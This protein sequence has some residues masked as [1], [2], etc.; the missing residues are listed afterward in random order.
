MSGNEG[1]PDARTTELEKER[2]GI[3]EEYGFIFS[4]PESLDPSIAI[5]KGS[6]FMISTSDF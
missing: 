2:D 4:T 5:E 1:E 3:A 6:F